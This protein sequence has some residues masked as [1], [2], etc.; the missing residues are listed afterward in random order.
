MCWTPLWLSA[1]T[2][3]GCTFILLRFTDFWLLLWY[4]KLYCWWGCTQQW[5]AKCNFIFYL[6][7]CKESLSSD[8]NQFDQ[9][10]QIKNKSP[11]VTTVQITLRHNWTTH[12][13]TVVTKG[14]LY[15]CDEGWFVQLWRRVICTVVTKGDL[16]S[17]DEGWFVHL[18]RRVIWTVVTMGDL[19]LICWYTHLIRKRPRHMTLKIQDLTWDRHKNVAGI[20][21]LIESQSSPL[22]NWISN[23]STYINKR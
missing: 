10:Q 23:G 8:S 6:L 16:F 1:S 3:S 21:R 9:Y 2:P 19:F 14:D 15:S 22:D 20:N 18:W 11:I 13:C 7:L 4:L 5:M 17:C 12:R